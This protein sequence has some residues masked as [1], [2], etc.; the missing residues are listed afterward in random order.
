MSFELAFSFVATIGMF[1]AGVLWSKAGPRHENDYG[2]LLVAF[3]ALKGVSFYVDHGKIGIRD[4]VVATWM[5]VPGFVLYGISLWYLNG[6]LEI[7]TANLLLG[8]AVFSCLFL[9]FVVAMTVLF[10]IGPWTKEQRDDPFQSDLLKTIA[11]A[12]VTVIFVGTVIILFRHTEN[13]SERLALLRSW[14]HVSSL[15]VYSVITI[16]VMLPLIMKNLRDLKG[17]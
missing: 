16:R 15:I 13:L 8:F 6:F 10:S 9:A 12:T 17:Q 5:G 1:L 7:W 14:F 3:C 4:F 2:W 11:L